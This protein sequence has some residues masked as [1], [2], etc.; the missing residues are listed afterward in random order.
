[1][2]SPASTSTAPQKRNRALPILLV[3]AIAFV[4]WGAQKYSYN[5]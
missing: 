3:A 4:A 5:R 2:T 1:M